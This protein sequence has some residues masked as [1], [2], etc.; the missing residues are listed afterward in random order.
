MVK[1]KKGN[2]ILEMNQAAANRYLAKNVGWKVVNEKVE[3]KKGLNTIPLGKSG[4]NHLFKMY[5]GRDAKKEELDYWSNKS[6]AQLRPK[7]IKNQAAGRRDAGIIKKTVKQKKVILKPTSIP[8]STFKIP[9]GYEKIAHPSYSK[10]YTD[11]RPD[12][13]NTFLYGKLKTK[14]VK[15]NKNIETNKNIKTNKSDVIANFVRYHGRQP[16]PNELK[17]VIEYLTT[18]SPQEVERRLAEN[19][20]ITKGDIWSVYQKKINEQPKLGEPKQEKTIEKPKQTIEEGLTQEQKDLYKQLY[21]DIDNM[22]DADGNPYSIGQKA[23]LKEIVGMD[24]TSGQK[25][26]DVQELSKII[27]TA[28]TNAQTDLDPYYQKVGFR[29]LED[30]KNQM[31][32]IRNES[33]RYAQQEATNYKQKLANVK[34][35]L[36]TRGMT[37]SGVSRGT[38]GKETALQRG[39]L[40]VEG[41]VP[42]ARRYTWEDA[43]AGWQQN[44]R[45]IGT[46][47]ERYLGSARMA[48]FKGLAD[49]YGQG[50][51]YR[52]GQTSALYLPHQQGSQG[53]VGIGDLALERKR[54][55][56]KSKWNRIA[57][58]RSHI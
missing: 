46:E 24:L 9:T 35:N 6:D 41:V 31:A 52:T 25:V 20:P 29:S 1:I 21:S 54:E 19:S 4:V 58:A 18:K 12:P 42:Q 44:A 5:Y 23:I 8:R 7:L 33:A 36:R 14:N 39:G 13:T 50:R 40:G 56:E 49:P 2:L 10:N 26:P 11:I 38:L 32:N 53:Y 22:T 45:N 3:K 48:S 57:S 51:D 17:G 28:A 15:A 43:R 47:A 30:L 37:F 34:Q 16:Y 27:E 55:I